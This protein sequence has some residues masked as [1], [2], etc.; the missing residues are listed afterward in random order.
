MGEHE[1]SA[2]S[3]AFD[4]ATTV[5]LP[6]RDRAVR[7]TGRGAEASSVRQAQGVG[8]EDW[9][10]L[11]TTIRRPPSLGRDGGPASVR[12]STRRLRQAPADDRPLLASSTA[13]P[14]PVPASPLASAF[15]RGEDVTRMNIPRFVPSRAGDT[16]P[17]LRVRVRA[18][19]SAVRRA[20]IALALIIALIFGVR[21]HRQHHRAA[22]PAPVASRPPAPLPASASTSSLASPP[23]AT[24][25]APARVSPPA[26]VVKTAPA[27]RPL[28]SAQKSASRV[29]PSP[30]ERAAIEAVQTGAVSEAARIYA[31]LAG[32][33]PGNEAYREAARILLES[34]DGG[35]ALPGPRLTPKESR[36]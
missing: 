10:E 31:A 24:A 22:S 23:L 6:V 32:A 20:S 15:A 33:H 27:P 36:P 1:R 30:D 28:A 17:A 25:T 3:M 9:G 13:S 19:R 5:D 18:R 29:S 35:S 14:T 8:S 16:Q 4:D 7:H 21:W 2:S 34:S 26:P 12:A 11:P